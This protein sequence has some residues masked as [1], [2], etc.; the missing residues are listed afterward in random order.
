M[1]ITGAGPV[2]LRSLQAALAFGAQEVYVSDVNPSRLA[3]AAELGASRTINP[4]LDSLVDLVVPPDVLLECSGFASAI[5]DGTRALDRAGRA[6]LVGMGGDEVPIPLSVVQEKEL[7]LTGT[8]RYANTWPTAIALVASGR[9]DLDRLQTGSYGLDQVEEALTAGRRDAHAIKVI[10]HPTRR[11]GPRGGRRSGCWA[12][13]PGFPEDVYRTEPFPPR[14]VP[15]PSRR[16][17]GRN[18]SRCAGIKG[19]GSRRFVR[20]VGR[21]RRLCRSR[22][23]RRR[24]RRWWWR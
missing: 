23:W 15:L 3:F 21:D 17:L 10:V 7:T 18:D 11:S 4:Q 24:W 1:L 5:V 12:L 2:G 14:H 20:V 13:M 6:V 16:H 9:I 22:R 19:S 8:F